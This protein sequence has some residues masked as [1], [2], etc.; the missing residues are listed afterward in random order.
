ML[1]GYGSIALEILRDIPYV[2]AI[3]VPVGTGGLAAA[4]ATVVKHDKP[5][6]LVYVSRPLKF[7]YQTSFINYNLIGFII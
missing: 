1:E 7:M 3:I 4:I 2:D 5:D 6:C